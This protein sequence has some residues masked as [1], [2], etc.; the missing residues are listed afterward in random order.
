[1][2]YVESSGLLVESFFFIKG[3]VGFCFLMGRKRILSILEE[4]TAAVVGHCVAFALAKCLLKDYSAAGFDPS[5]TG[6]AAS[7]PFFDLCFL[8]LLL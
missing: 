8:L 2:E 1:M 4:P 7:S 5:S 6:A 3:F